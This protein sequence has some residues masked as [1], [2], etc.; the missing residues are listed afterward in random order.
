[1]GE[2]GADHFGSGVAGGGDVNKDDEL[3]FV[4]TAPNTGGTVQYGSAY[5]FYGPLSGT[6]SAADHDARMD[7]DTLNDNVGSNV[8]FVGD[9]DGG[10]ADAFLVG[11]PNKDT[12]GE[13]GGGAYL[14]L[15]IGL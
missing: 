6:V 1:V 2:A 9:V 7:G 14:M 10:G 13:D 15:D 12:I 11:A 3:D 5:V 4:V 8:A